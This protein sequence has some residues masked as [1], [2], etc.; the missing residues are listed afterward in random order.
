MNKFVKQLIESF[1]DDQD[2]YSDDVYKDVADELHSDTIDKFHNIPYN[3]TLNN[4]D[5]YIFHNDL[6]KWYN[7]AVAGSKICE[8][9]TKNQRTS[10]EF[11]FECR[12]GTKYFRGPDHAF[13]FTK[14]STL[15]MP[16]V[17]EPVYDIVMDDQY[18]N[19]KILTQLDIESTVGR[20]FVSHINPEKVLYGTYCDFIAEIYPFFK[21]DEYCIVNNK[22]VVFKQLDFYA[23]KYVI[24]QKIVDSLPLLTI[25][26]SQSGSNKTELFKQKGLLFKFGKSITGDN[27]AIRF[28]TEETARNFI[29]KLMDQGIKKFTVQMI[30][31]VYIIENEK[32]A[33]YRGK[34]Y[35]DFERILCEECHKRKLTF[36][37]DDATDKFKVQNTCEK[38]YREHNI[39][40]DVQRDEKYNRDRIWV[41]MH[42]KENN[43]GK[44]TDKIEKGKDKEGSYTL[45]IVDINWITND[46]ITHSGL[47]GWRLYK[48]GICKLNNIYFLDRIADKENGGY[49]EI[50]H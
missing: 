27:T 19:I 9:F 22:N 37:V 12:T 46:G 20:L 13:V 17:H 21:I 30:Y 43:R 42:S 1:L 36:R 11:Y 33:T 25:C 35:F 18:N 32:N 14:K 48:S 15:T 31:S 28:D 39:L 40:T 44:Q 26:D 6:H 50:E 5:A 47:S 34:S 4:E 23:P 2:L 49:I 7:Y 24:T 41:N 29:I 16:E 45:Y 3:A 38:Y 10:I 8:Y